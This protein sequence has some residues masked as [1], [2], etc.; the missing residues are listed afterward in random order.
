MTTG[1]PAPSSTGALTILTW[2][3]LALVGLMAG[4]FF[5]YSV[6]VMVGLDRVNDATFIET[7]QWINATVRNAGFG[8]AYFGALGVTGVATFM[9]YT[10]GRRQ[11]AMWL[12]VAFV[13]YGIAFMITV[14]FSIPLNNQL[15]DAGEVSKIA[16]LAA[17]RRDYE[18]DWVQWNNIRAAFNGASLVALGG[19]M[20]QLGRDDVTMDGSYSR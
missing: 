18:G 3:S 13:L 7:M 17:V 2:L 14:S 8:P 5:A 10:A 12:L 4:F 15:R 20:R 1:T 6:S 9:A 11:L 16:D 19:A